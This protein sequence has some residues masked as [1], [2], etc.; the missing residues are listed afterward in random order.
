MTAITQLLKENGYKQVQT[1]LIL[2][3]TLSIPFMTV[4]TQQKQVKLQGPSGEM[5]AL[6][7]DST[8]ALVI[9]DVLKNVT[10]A[11][12][13]R[14]YYDEPNFYQ[15]FEKRVI[16]E[17]RQVG[18]EI[19]SK[20]DKTGFVEALNLAINLAQIV[21]G[22]NILV[23]ISHAALLRQ[24]I[25][26]LADGD[27][28]KYDALVYYLNRKNTRE[29][30]KLLSDFESIVSLESLESFQPI[31]NWLKEIQLAI[32]GTQREGLPAVSVHFDP[33]LIVD[34]PYYTG[35]TFKIYD[36]KRHINIITGG[37]YHFD[38]YGVS[39]CGFSIKYD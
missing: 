10:P 33:A 5:L 23:E 13:H 22:P 2:D 19:I 8:I 35:E 32:R 20:Q 25:D 36:T 16:A 31:L 17:V 30:L 26:H 29:V 14:I 24:V 6:R 1:P 27:E 7:G 38:T 28:K 21:C 12:T 18:I 3:Y 37:S 11:S 9:C 34:K 15:D 4:E 39:G